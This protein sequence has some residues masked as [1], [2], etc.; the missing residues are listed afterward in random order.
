[1]SKEKTLQHDV[2]F[3]IERVFELQ[4]KGKSRDQGIARKLCQRS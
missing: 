4:F 1:M 2:S 3:F